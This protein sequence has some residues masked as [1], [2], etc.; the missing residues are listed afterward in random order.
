MDKVEKFCVGNCSKRSKKQMIKRIQGSPSKR[1]ARPALDYGFD[2]F[3][4]VNSTWEVK[5]ESEFR[6]Y[7]FNTDLFYSNFLIIMKRYIDV[8][9]II[10]LLNTQPVHFPIND[11]Y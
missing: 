5:S 4:N 8:N 1:T 3:V 7:I 2:L 11:L 10:R 6:V 9:K